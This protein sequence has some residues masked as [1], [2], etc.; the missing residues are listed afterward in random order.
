MNKKDLVAS[1]SHINL[2]V[3]LQLTSTLPKPG[4][5]DVYEPFP[6]SEF[7]FLGLSTLF[8]DVTIVLNEERQFVL[9]TYGWH[10]F[11][12]HWS[13]LFRD[14]ASNMF[15]RDCVL[16]ICSYDPA[17]DDQKVSSKEE[18][19]SSSYM[20][21]MSVDKKRYVDKVL[22]ETFKSKEMKTWRYHSPKL[23]DM[24]T[25]TTI[26]APIDIGWFEQQYAKYM[27]MQRLAIKFRLDADKGSSVWGNGGTTPLEPLIPVPNV[28]AVFEHKY[29]I[30]TMIADIIADDL[31]L[32]TVLADTVT[33]SSVATDD[34]FPH[35]ATNQTTAVSV[36][37]FFRLD[38]TSLMTGDTI[39]NSRTVG[40]TVGGV[41]RAGAVV[42][43][44]A[45]TSTTIVGNGTQIWVGTTAAAVQAHSDTYS[46]Y[47]LGWQAYCLILV[48]LKNLHEDSG[49]QLKYLD[50]PLSEPPT[51]TSQKIDKQ[52]WFDVLTKYP[53]SVY[54][55]QS[56]RVGP[57]AHTEMSD[58]LEDKQN[59]TFH[60]WKK[61]DVG[62]GLVA[63][64]AN[65]TNNFYTVDRSSSNSSLGETF[66]VSKGSMRLLCWM[67]AGELHYVFQ[68]KKT[69]L[70]YLPLHI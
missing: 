66:S 68:H 18:F 49:N 23:E 45:S 57:Q 43:L 42:G 25:V 9:Y 7:T 60:H 22:R 11:Q 34:Q 16:G 29:D 56:D 13:K 50:L 14:N 20:G 1:L 59:S 41:P 70:N 67:S 2:N 62:S 65:I 15:D 35:G 30:T 10:T 55:R 26:S 33:T 5:V 61:S 53:P 19:G 6:D 12:T 54:L 52:E 69:T 51:L 38:D 21:E 58:Y 40:L 4:S 32:K 44:S 17:D 31:Q 3:Q 47:V 37:V 64:T 8:R 28:Q 63:D 24:A 46:T 39:V 36:H 27:T 48:K